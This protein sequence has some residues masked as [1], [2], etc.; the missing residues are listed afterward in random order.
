KG[1]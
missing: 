1:R